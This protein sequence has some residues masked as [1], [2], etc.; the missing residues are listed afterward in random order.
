MRGMPVRLLLVVVWLI[1]WAGVAWGQPFQGPPHDGGPGFSPRGPRHAPRAAAA[2]LMA[3]AGRE[4]QAEHLFNS[5]RQFIE[6][7]YY[8]EGLEAINQSLALRPQH[9]R[10]LAYKGIALRALREPRLALQQFDAALA[11]D[12]KDGVA[13]GERGLTLMVLGEERRAE[14]DLREAMRLR[15]DLSGWFSQQGRWMA[16]NRHRIYGTAR[17]QAAAQ[18]LPE[19]PVETAPEGEQADESA[20]TAEGPRQTPGAGLHRRLRGWSAPSFSV[21]DA[22]SLLKPAA[23]VAMVFLLGLLALRLLFALVRRLVRR[24]AVPWRSQLRGRSVDGTD[25]PFRSGAAPPLPAGAAPA[26]GF[27]LPRQPLRR[28]FRGVLLLAGVGFFAMAVFAVPVL[29][30]AF[31]LD[32]TKL[33]AQR[34]R[35]SVLDFRGSVYTHL[36]APDT[37]VEFSDLP[38]HLVDA[39][40]AREDSRFFEHHGVDWIGLGRAFLADVRHL[41]I[42]EGASTLTMQLVEKVYHL[43]Q[44][45]LLNRIRSKLVE[46]TM[47]HRAEAAAARQFGD[48]RAAKEAIMTAYL[49][50][51]EFGGGTVGVGAASLYF[52]DKPVSEL[53]LGESCMLVALLRAPTANSPYRNPDNARLARDKIVAQ[54]VRRGFISEEQA[55][56]ARF[57][58]VENPR[59]PKPGHNGY[60][61]AAITREMNALKAEKKLPADIWDHEDLVIG[62][63][64]DLWAQDILDSEVRKVV[65]SFKGA[66]SKDPLGGAG[67]IVDNKT[68]QIRALVSGQ[69]YS[70]SQYDLAL[71]SRRQVASI[72][73]T[74]VYGAYLERGGDIR[75]LAKNT[76]LTEQEIRALNDWNPRNAS[77]LKA[78]E[79]PLSTGLAFSDNL[80]TVRVGLQAGLRRVYDTLYAAGMVSDKTT[81]GTT[82]LL[83]SFDSSLAQ[84]ASA[85]TAMP[86]GGSRVV[87][88]LVQSVSVGGKEVYR[89]QPQTKPLFSRRTAEQLHLALREAITDG[90]GRSAMRSAGVQTSVAGKTGTSQN[91]ADVWW[92]GYGK[93]VTLGVRFGRNSNASL[94]SSATAST[95]AAPVAARVLKKLS[96]RYALE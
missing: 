26:S 58:V 95:L 54:M 57:L 6:Q 43:E 63:T 49:N 61:V 5:G 34:V 71:T 13:R 25:H 94:G 86:R 60:L 53:T 55:K 65:S 1:C 30:Q 85:Y 31:R 47:A 45:G 11:V 69:D 4:R 33:T 91:A 62:S 78:G 66:S 7:G 9:A 75:E 90:T 3:E 48:R 46:W 20:Q 18:P 89:A 19:V 29:V 64:L 12:P 21:W 87:P 8:S 74:F 44:K 10:A 93:D 68:G 27:S 84:V 92:V 22:T 52:F 79:Y 38:Q 59:K 35:P 88:Y 73:K 82:W 41:R 28:R 16:A 23:F 96:E 72:A 36:G 51:V 2:G 39:L 76:P 15:P 24:A 14:E 77:S 83:G 50:R 56:Q 70:K 32:V 80:I 42:K 40:R 17:E 81:T 37:P 67:L